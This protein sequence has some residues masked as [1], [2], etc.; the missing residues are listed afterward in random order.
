M[1]TH[2]LSNGDQEQIAAAKQEL[3]IDD[4]LDAV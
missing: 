4:C 2:A 1:Q 3:H